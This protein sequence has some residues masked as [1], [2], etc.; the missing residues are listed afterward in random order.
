MV[1]N[2]KP[3][4]MLLQQG[5]KMSI[6]HT[7]KTSPLQ[8][9]TPEGFP[10]LGMSICPGKVDPCA[11]SGSCNRDLATDIA[12]IQHWG[13]RIVVTLMEDSELSALHVKNLGH[14]VEKAGMT[15]WHFTV[16]DGSALKMRQSHDNCHIWDLPCALLR[17]LISLGGKIFI[18]CRGGLGRTGTLAAR[19][20]IEEGC[21]PEKAISLIRKAR[22]G[23]IETI[24]QETYLLNLPPVLETNKKRN[25]VRAG[26]IGGAIG[27]A[28][29]HSITT[30]KKICTSASDY[31][32]HIASLDTLQITQST[33]LSLFTTEALIRSY[34]SPPAACPRLRPLHA[35]IDK[36]LNKLGNTKNIEA[37]KLRIVHE[38]AREATA[39][40]TQRL[41]YL[42]PELCM[43][44]FALRDWRT[45]QSNISTLVHSKGNGSLFLT[46]PN[47][48]AGLQ[49]NYVNTLPESKTFFPTNSNKGNCSIAR[50]T[51]IGLISAQYNFIP[52]GDKQ[53]IIRM[54]DSNSAQN[55]SQ[56]DSRLGFNSSRLTHSDPVTSLVA[57]V[58]VRL[59]SLFAFDN[60]PTR[61]RLEKL[62]EDISR[63]SNLISIDNSLHELIYAAFTFGRKNYL[64]K[65]PCTEIP[66]QLGTGS[67]ADEALAIALYCTIAHRRYEDAIFAAINHATDSSDIPILISQL[68][69]LLHGQKGFPTTLISK[70][71]Y[72]STIISMADTLSA[73]SYS[74]HEIRMMAGELW[75]NADFSFLLSP[76]VNAPHHSDTLEGYAAKEQAAFI[77][78]PNGRSKKL[79]K[80]HKHPSR[81]CVQK[82][83]LPER[84]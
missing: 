6:L 13:A 3:C 49:N 38:H 18:H 52:T 21:E 59:V 42:Y 77:K 28:M 74:P 4:G 62:L 11:M 78:L 23:A 12:C 14:A 46:Y 19:I 82:I 27:D 71:K 17:L 45:L 79:V 60:A 76:E 22:P 73:I 29:E 58:W 72:R 51:S 54:D 53:Y 75:P 44:Y 16:V 39:K 32:N 15:W 7:S 55:I 5:E 83:K 34:T 1:N 70:L 67:T 35:K 56:G 26:M 31:I 9:A 66:S 40:A 2:F 68:W 36:L 81:N 43:Q 33:L 50:L 61:E 41:K 25:I 80:L 69:G 84:P 65:N 30:S 57:G 48:G 47:E 63:Y 64:S 20:L 24:E 8:I 37:N 10:G